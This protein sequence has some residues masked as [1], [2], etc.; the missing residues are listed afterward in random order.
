MYFGLDG[1]C[2]YDTGAPNVGTLT[3][4]TLDLPAVTQHGSITLQYCHNLETESDPEYDIPTVLVNAAVIDQP[5]DADVWQMQSI[6][7]TAFA[8][9]TVTIEW[10]F[11]TVDEYYNDQ[12]GWQIDLVTII[13]TTIECMDVCPGDLDGDAIVGVTDL[14]ALLG[15]WGA[16]GPADLDGDGFVDVEDMLLLLAAWGPC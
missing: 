7:L 1:A 5:A 9:E 14:L 12:R 4:P 2:D 8:G 15:D 11:D 16:A 6:D 13:S 3:S 10:S